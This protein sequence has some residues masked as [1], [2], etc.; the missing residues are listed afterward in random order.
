MQALLVREGLTVFYGNEV[1]L[2]AFYAGWLFWLGAG[3]LAV[4]YRDR[5]APLRGLRQA[6]LALPLL[7]C[8]QVLALRTVRL[9]L[10][11]S[12]GQLVPLGELFV[13]L[14]L[15]AAPAALVL[16]AA[17]PL[18]CRV[19][20]RADQA[21][22]GS[23]LVTRLY[24]ADAVGA[25]GGGLVF[26]LVLVHWAGPVR[27]LGLLML[28][29]AFMAWRLAPL[30]RWGTPVAAG[31]LVLLGL[32]L[33]LPPTSERIGAAL[34]RLRFATLQPGMT[35]LAAAE[36]RY[37]HRAVARLGEQYSL[38][39]D[40][41]IVASF[42]RPDGLARE[43]ALLLAQAMPSAD[44]AAGPRRVLALDGLAGGPVPALLRG[45]AP[46]DRLDQVEQDRAAFELARP[47]LDAGD[48]S[49]PRLALH[50]ADGRRFVTGLGEADRYDL[51]LALAAVPSSAAGN[52]YFT[53]DFYAAVRA[54]LTPR[55]VFC[56]RVAA[57]S[58]YLGETVGGYLGS[59][60][61]TLSSVF[62]EVAV[63]PGD[64]ALLCASPATGQ[65]SDDADA[66][67]RRWQAVGGA[68]GIGR[69]DFATLLPAEEV[70]YLRERLAE[71]PG[72][73][74]TDARP[75]TY[76][77]NMVLWGTFS[78]SGLVAL[79]ERLHGLGVWP[80]LLP[81]V[82]FVL[83]WLLRLGVDGGARQR[84]PRQSA[85]F[86]LFILGLAAMAAQLVVLFAY[87]AR[88]GF[89]FE[90]IALLNGLFMTGLA[91]GAALALPTARAAGVVLP[92][93]LA[94]TAAVLLGMPAG[95]ALIGT[96]PPWWQDAAFL[97]CALALGGLTGAGFPLAVALTRDGRTEIAKRG[98][99]AQAA[100][101][102]GG[103]VG[104]LVAGGLMVPLLG[105]DGT[106]R[107]LAVLLVLTLPP[108]LATRLPAGQVR[109][110]GLALPAGLGWGLIFLVVLAYG[111]HWLDRA[112]A[113]A[114][115]VDFSPTLLAEVAEADAFERLEAPFVHYLGGVA[116]DGGPR[117]VALSSRAAGADSSGYGGPLN[118]LLALQRDGR[119][120]GVRLVAS[121]ETPAYI[122]G[123]DEWLAGLRG[124]SL[125]DGPLSGRVDAIAGATVTSRAALASIDQAA[126]R[127]ARRHSV[128]RCRCSR[129]RTG[130][131]WTRG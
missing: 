58:N 130:R 83:V 86:A 32:V 16:G 63:V 95:L 118:L 117:W 36:T 25:L 15:I 96:L 128:N 88:V 10:D 131:T 11:V 97:A 46:I 50:F 27:T 17:F 9:V 91:L 72:E 76:Y 55:G 51:I 26:T 122:A 33:S 7:L 30:R 112:A 24:L 119:L 5:S 21:R 103:A 62:A 99:L 107:V 37:G 22:Q 44:P 77:L 31:L 67:A 41:Q 2:G 14:F 3:A 108:L 39:E 90:R 87:Q 109:G 71:H 113:P 56:T 92:L 102:L 53:R 126:A 116:A 59:V 81:V 60:Y 34:E 73:L 80:Y 75:V 66:L 65:V 121:N 64:E 68:G 42:P 43:A 19:L 20:A 4:L 52:R 129:R 79:L 70:R 105:V 124:R 111:W 57:A 89:M 49:D 23:G 123:I 61:R 35:L 47:W 38:V 101:N 69:A 100:D 98:G 13:A 1:S 84:L 93:L 45:P 29:C 125:A 18:A 110:G 85:T 40:G 78:A 94:L 82:L 127:G 48:I 104:A 106:S 8:G 74:N 28:A 12:A 6:L 114:V 54:Q 120:G 115:Q